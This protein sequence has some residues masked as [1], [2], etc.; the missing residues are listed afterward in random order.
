MP[1]LSKKPMGLNS[2]FL[3]FAALV[4][5]GSLVLWFSSLSLF[6]PLKTKPTS[7][8][9]E[10]SVWWLSAQDADLNHTVMVWSH[11]YFGA[12]WSDMVKW[13]QGLLPSDLPSEVWGK[14]R[15]DWNRLRNLA[16]EASTFQFFLRLTSSM[17]PGW[18][19]SS[20]VPPFSQLTHK[21]VRKLEHLMGSMIHKI[22]LVGFQ[23]H[24]EHWGLQKTWKAS[25]NNVSTQYIK[26]CTFLFGSVTDPVE[27]GSSR[28][29]AETFKCLPLAL[30]TLH[31][32]LCKPS[33]PPVLLPFCTLPHTLYSS[34]QCLEV[35]CC[36]NS[37][38][39]PPSYFSLLV[40]WAEILHHWTIEFIHQQQ[41][42]HGSAN[43]SQLKCTY[44]RGSTQSTLQKKKGDGSS[45]KYRQLLPFPSSKNPSKPV[46]DTISSPLNCQPLNDSGMHTAWTDVPVVYATNWL[47]SMLSQGT[48][49]QSRRSGC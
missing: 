46:S 23:R 39:L 37:K 40:H 42:Y 29:A 38:H 15:G 7:L 3:N 48:V 13:H 28:R 43:L 35:W 26:T 4:Q 6:Q 9:P 34:Q 20:S 31:L 36:L 33:G 30:F 10:C 47:R 11:R 5:T 41:A 45:D 49:N 1:L 17:T 27:L 12:S 2:A 32:G 16:I 24:W 8:R 25:R 44:V 18:S 21:S 22:A 19:C 14:N